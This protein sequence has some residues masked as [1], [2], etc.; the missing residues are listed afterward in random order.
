ML[1]ILIPTYNYNAYPLACELEKQALALDID[2]ELICMDDGSLSKLNIENQKIN[3]LTNSKFIESQTNLGRTARRQKLAEMAQYSWLLLLDA[4]VFPKENTF[5]VN[6]VKAIRLNYSIYFG[7]LSYGNTSH[8]EHKELR[9]TFGRLREEI[10]AAT[11]NKN[12]YKIVT[13]GNVLVQKKIYQKLFTDTLGKSYGMDYYFGS[14]LKKNN[15]KVFHL[16][17]EV[18]HNGIDTNVEF[19]K[20]TERAIE[21]LK[22]LLSNKTIDTSSIS[23]IKAYKF[24]TVTKLNILYKQFF[25]FFKSSFRKNLTGK[26]PNLFIFDLYRLGILVTTK[27]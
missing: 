18:Y 23:L 17:N 21:N 27:N 8:A 9:Y 24:L 3:R 11:R 14:C 4:D 2:F 20:K 26:N 5:L 22:S 1:S 15:V 12:P 13:S 6:Y 19:L 25:I 7:G 10:N 16:D